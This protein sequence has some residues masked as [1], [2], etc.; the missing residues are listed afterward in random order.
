MSPRQ[1][2]L[3][4]AVEGFASLAFEV[5]ALRRIIPY[6]G[7]AIT[8]TAPTIA[9]FLAAL[10]LGYFAA[11]RVR[12]DYER[13]VLRNFVLA[14]LIG[15][16]LLSEW[17]A[18]LVFGAIPWPAVA[19]PVYL[20]AAMAPPAYF[21]AQTVPVLSNIL[22]KARVGE[23]GGLALA[24]STAGSVLGA[25]GLSMVV[26]Q[27]LGVRS[28]VLL[29]ALGLLGVAAWAALRMRQPRAVAFIALCALPIVGA[30]ALPPI[31]LAETA[32][33]D[34]DVR[35]LPTPP[36]GTAPNR[37][38]TVNNQYASTLDAGAPPLRA[39][40]IEHIASQLRDARRFGG[41]EVLVL[42]AGGFVLSMGDE[43][44]AYTYVDIDPAIRGLAERHFLG[45]PDA[46]GTIRGRF[47]ADDARRFVLRDG[48]RYDAIVVDA[49][50][51]H[52]TVPPQLVTVEFWRSLRPRLAEGGV[53]F[54]NLILDPRLQDAYARNALASVEAALGQCATH[55]VDPLAERSNVVL[56]CRPGRSDPPPPRPY[57][58]DRNAVDWDRQV[59]PR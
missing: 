11:S 49:F 4:V 16:C 40:Y 54:I 59:D 7:S 51:S 21:L 5:I 30:N 37:V 12:A 8:V 29:T 27:H 23:A 34:Y 57:T 42:G 17:G 48:P 9:I 39:A 18:A 32:Y 1:L 50:S 2:L 47:V 44:N 22:G 28:A 15:G 3:L 58:D 53:V 10:A 24:W 14:A 35:V 41:G 38:F 56:A 31:H 46:P 45:T 26:M 52:T 20:A 36:G 13:T 25:L 43:R 19:L 55:V 33:A 6:V